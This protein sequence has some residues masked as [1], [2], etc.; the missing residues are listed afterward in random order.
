MLSIRLQRLGRKGYP[1]YR[2]VVQEGRQS[3]DSGKYV[4]LLGS[5]N[6]HTK[7]ITL[8]KEK[9]ELYL[10]NGAQPSDRVVSLFKTQKVSLPGWVK[11]PSKQERKLRNAEKLRKNRSEEPVAEESTEQPE[12]E[13]EPA[14]EEASVENAEVEVAKDEA[15]PEEPAESAD[16][17]ERSEAQEA[18]AEGQNEP[19][20]TEE[21]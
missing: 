8:D 17:A 19:E 1:V 7:E 9:A 6:P 5:Y 12:G 14:S 21:K 13:A 18:P 2:I 16:P 11:E 4:A 3:P 10:K 15:N 20:Q